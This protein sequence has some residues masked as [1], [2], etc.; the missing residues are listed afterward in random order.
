MSLADELT[1]LEQLR[2]GGTLT[3]EEFDRAKRKL[4]DEPASPAT[5][6]SLA[7]IQAQN[8]LA[9]LDRDW[10]R[11]RERYMVADSYGHKHLPGRGGSLVS[12]VVVAAFGVFWLMM[13]GPES[14]FGMGGLFSLF[15]FLF[16]AVGVGLSLRAFAKADEYRN[17]HTLY[18]NRRK[19]LLAREHANPSSVQRA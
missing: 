6:Q 15:G 5:A 19:A 11:E 7:I 16:I 12:A 2:R 4:L 3:P 17:A 10:D 1:K 13:P 18:Q 8:E 9:Q 14:A